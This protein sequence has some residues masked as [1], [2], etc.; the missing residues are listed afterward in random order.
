L[1]VGWC[2]WVTGW[3]DEAKQK[4]GVKSSTKG[5]GEGQGKEKGINRFNQR[6]SE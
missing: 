6:R 5:K 4:K 2:V 1:I 3:F